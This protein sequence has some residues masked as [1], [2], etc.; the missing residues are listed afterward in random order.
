MERKRME[1]EMNLD[2]VRASKSV[3]YS[4]RRRWKR[5]SLLQNL[6]LSR[7]LYF[8]IDSTTR[9]NFLQGWCKRLFR[10]HFVYS[11]ERILWKYKYVNSR[12]ASNRCKIKY[13]NFGRWSRITRKRCKIK[14]INFGGW[15]RLTRKI[16]NGKNIVKLLVIP[17]VISLIV[18]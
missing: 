6:S 9:N 14:Y 16:R 4:G 7:L 5:E 1:C 10:T 13:I 18:C 8:S 15:S 17:R 2:C 12:K 11:Y 3:N